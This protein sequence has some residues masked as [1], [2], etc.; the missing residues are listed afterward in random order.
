MFAQTALVAGLAVLAAAYLLRQAW[1]TWSGGCTSCSGGC[2]K[3]KKVEAAG[4]IRPD[5]LLD[6]VRGRI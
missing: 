6:R 5:E 1:K 2:G 4:L 3:P